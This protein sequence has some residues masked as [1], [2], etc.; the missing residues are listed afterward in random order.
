M[1]DAARCTALRFGRAVIEIHPEL[2]GSL[3]R[4]ELESSRGCSTLV[5][6]GIIRR[7]VEMDDAALALAVGTPRWFR[8]ATPFK[9]SIA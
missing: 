4:N 8:R 3:H 6:I 5:R 7:A 1:A 2:D 9:V